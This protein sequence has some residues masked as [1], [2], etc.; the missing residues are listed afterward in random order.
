MEPIFTNDAVVF[1]MLMVV[2]AAV[3]YTSHLETPGWKKFYTYV[4]ALLLCYFLPALL[5]WPLGLIAS[6]WF[7][8]SLME[9]LASKNLVLPEGTTSFGQIKFFA[10]GTN[11]YDAVKN[12]F[13]QFSKGK[14]AIAFQANFVQQNGRTATLKRKGR[15]L[16]RPGQLF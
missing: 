11:S 5:H 16:G 12:G 15:R 8:P 6:E 4:P 7:D 3:F 13:L 9:F 1:G 2:L 10:K 14:K